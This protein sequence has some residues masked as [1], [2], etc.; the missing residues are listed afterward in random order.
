MSNIIGVTFKDEGKVYYYSNELQ[1]LNVNDYV[2]VSREG[3]LYVAKVVILNACNKPCIKKSGEIERKA[4]KDDISSY[5]KN[6]ADAVKAVKKSKEISEKY[7]LN[8]NIVDALFSLDRSQLLITF[9]SDVRVDFR[10]MAKDLASIYKTRIELRQIG[11]RDKAREV[12]GIGPCGCELC[13]F[14]FLSE[15]MDAVSINMAKNQ[16]LSLNPT[17]INGQCGRLLCCLK[18]E[19]DVY[20]ENRCK[21]PQIGDVMNT[22]AGKGEVVSLDIL[23][24]KYTIKLSDESLV[25]VDADE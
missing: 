10:E 23:R 3:L 9:L 19:D 16:N 18:Y 25:E 2:V 22:K 13:C 15:N 20:T 7:K 12:S 11:A 5:E 8:M 21:L 24:K 14:R 1:D 17:K 4:T 6:L